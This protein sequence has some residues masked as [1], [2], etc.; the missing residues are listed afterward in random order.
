M[1]KLHLILIT[2][3]AHFCVCR[4]LPM[5]MSSRI[6]TRLPSAQYLPTELSPPK[7]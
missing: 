4:R 5:R 6:G 2:S 1:N 7:P 3:T